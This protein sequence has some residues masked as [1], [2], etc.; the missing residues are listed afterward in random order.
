MERCSFRDGFQVSDKVIALG[1]W[2]VLNY[3]TLDS[4]KNRW[5]L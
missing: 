3:F 4:E 5:N 1:N 2:N